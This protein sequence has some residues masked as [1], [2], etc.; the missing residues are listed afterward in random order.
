MDIPIEMTKFFEMIDGYH[1]IIGLVV[2]GKDINQGNEVELTGFV[3]GHPTIR[4]LNLKSYIF[5]ADDTIQFIRQSPNS[6]KR[7]EFQIKGRSDR[8]RIL[9]QLGNSGWQYIADYDYD[10]DYDDASDPSYNDDSFIN[11]E[12][13][14]LNVD[15][16]LKR[17]ITIAMVEIPQKCSKIPF[18]NKNHSKREYEFS[19]IFYLVKYSFSLF[20]LG[21][22]WCQTSAT[23]VALQIADIS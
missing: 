23:W 18:L 1:S 11:I 13:E 20:F 9:A 22:N 5:K 4:N 14:R 16:I 6:L 3:N 12:L 17:F 2:A 10:D 19:F 15:W 7:F 8:D 21:S